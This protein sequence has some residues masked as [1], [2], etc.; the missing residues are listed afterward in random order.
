MRFAKS[1]VTHSLENDWKLWKLLRRWNRGVMTLGYHGVIR[2]EDFH[3][4]WIQ[5]L[6]IPLSTFE[7][8]MEF[9]ASNF[10]VLG[11]SEIQGWHS[12]KQAV[13]LTFD[14]GFA[15]FATTAM[16]VLRRLGLPASIYVISGYLDTQ[17]RLPT[18]VGRAAFGHCLPGRIEL[19]TAGKVF[20]VSDADSRRQAYAEISHLLKTGSASTV[21]GLV[22]ELKSLVH[23]DQWPEINAKYESDSMM[24]WAEVE[25]V[26]RAGITVGAHTVD[27]FAL[28]PEQDPGIAVSQI[29]ESVQAIKD[30]LGECDWFAYP[31]GTPDATSPLAMSELEKLGLSGAWT[32]IPG[33]MNRQPNPYVLPRMPV[34]RNI[35]RMRLA[36]NSPC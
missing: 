6:H 22:S 14:D 16:P 20:Q 9:I 27:H 13:H 4:E 30:R 5:Q 12:K 33:K 26:S 3:D 23:D 15:N 10:R 36:L 18:F 28:G 25:E 34:P 35:A 29:R 17:R 31:N 8:Q 21:V 11:A 1:I 7:A 32:L 24:T 19:D 2:D